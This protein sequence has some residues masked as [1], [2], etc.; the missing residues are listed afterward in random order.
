MKS[1]TETEKNLITEINK[2]EVL[3]AINSNHVEFLNHLIKE[4][5]NQYIRE[6]I[7]N[8]IEMINMK[9]QLFD[10]INNTEI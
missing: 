6:T 4:L 2:N 3:T 10:S 5:D 1:L 9:K 7:K 8:H